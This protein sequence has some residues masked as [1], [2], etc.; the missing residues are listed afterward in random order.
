MDN[1]PSHKDV[2]EFGSRVGAELGMT[3]LKD[4]ADSRVCALGAPGTD[5]RIPGLEEA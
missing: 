1:M 3:V 4:K 2:L 5:T